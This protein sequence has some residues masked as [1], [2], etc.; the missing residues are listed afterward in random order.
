MKRTAGAWVVLLSMLGGCVSTDSPSASSSDRMMGGCPG[1]G[2]IGA[3]EI[4]GMTGPYGEPVAMCAPY[5]GIGVSGE[6]AARAMIANSIPLDQMQAGLAA[7][8]AMMQ[9]GGRMGAS[10]SSAI[11]QASA[12][13]P[14]GANSDVVQASGSCPIGGCPPVAG[15][16]AAVGAMRGGMPCGPQFNAR[17]TSVRFATPAGMKI[18]WYAP[19]PDGKVGFTSTQIE[20]PGRYN[21]LQGAI[22]RLKLTDIPNR[23]GLELYPTLEVVPA[24]NKTYPFLAHSA[25][26]IAFTDEDFDQVAAGNFVVKVIYL[27]DPQFQDL[28]TATD[29]VVSSRLEPGVDPIA[30]AHR[31]GSILLVVRIGN[32]DLEAPNTP[33]MDAPC[34]YPPGAAAPGMPGPMMPG[35]AHSGGPAISGMPRPGMPQGMMPNG[36]M[37]NPMMAPGQGG[38]AMPNAMMVPGNP[39]MP[40]RGALMGNPGMLP[41]MV[42]APSGPQT[43]PALPG[44]DNKQ[45]KASEPKGAV[46]SAVALT[47]AA[48]ASKDGKAAADKKAAEK[49]AEKAVDKK[50]ADKK[51]A[52]KAVDKKAA[53]KSGEKKAAE[54]NGDKKAS[55]KDDKKSDDNSDDKKPAKKR[56][57]WFNR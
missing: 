32:I 13:M 2:G 33:P 16:V 5:A 19:T 45:S 53:E 21:F 12:M 9:A 44:M 1:R 30:E 39:M 10:P 35:V 37:P 6:A 51:A 27:P 17:R 3:R 31:R 15:A 40:P 43:V 7:N 50:A 54:K 26:P 24:N 20:A 34:A 46:V 49:A 18:A 56:M 29:E 11:M 25:V 38:P 8:A 14:P 23:P 57:L 55:D 36:M 48:L 4:P 41:N 52:E 28:A 47:P 42:P 22:Y